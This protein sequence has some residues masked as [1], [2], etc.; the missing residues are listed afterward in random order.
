[1]SLKLIRLHKT[2]KATF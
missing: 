1:M 2:E